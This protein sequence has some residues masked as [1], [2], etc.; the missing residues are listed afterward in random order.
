M[1]GKGLPIL[2]WSLALTI[3]LALNACP[4][5]PIGSVM[6]SGQIRLD[7]APVPS[8]AVLFSGDHVATSSTTA[9]VHLQNGDKLALGAS[10]AIEVSAGGGKW[11][12]RLNGG[13]ILVVGGKAP[14]LVRVSGVTAQSERMNGSYEVALWGDALEVWTRRGVTLVQGAKRTVE[15]PMGH[16]MNATVGQGRQTTKRGKIR[17]IALIAG[18]AAGAGLGIAL[19]MP[20]PSCVSPSRLN[21]R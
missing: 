21:C 7:G 9:S 10:T 8:G 6:S 4:P 1:R 14:I 11:I 5:V 17:N 18:A 3:P 15:V 12:V 19:T 13:K 20:G 16:R 2:V